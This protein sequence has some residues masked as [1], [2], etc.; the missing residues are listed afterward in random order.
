MPK[1]SASRSKCAC[2]AR[3]ALALLRHAAHGVLHG[4][5]GLAGLGHGHRRAGWSDCA[6]IRSDWLS[7]GHN[8]HMFDRFNSGRTKGDQRQRE[9]FVGG[10]GSI[11]ALPL[12]FEHHQLVCKYVMQIRLL[13]TKCTWRPKRIKTEQ[14][15]C[16]SLPCLLRLE[17]QQAKGKPHDQSDPTS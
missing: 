10:C 17:Y 13:F 3:L 4:F 11:K 16:G 6:R 1:S 7:I 14:W 2:A 9:R 8:G 15:W 5:A 12:G